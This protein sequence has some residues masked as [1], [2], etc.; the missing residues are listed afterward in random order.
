MSAP[1]RSMFSIR[2][3]V[4]SHGSVM[5]YDLGREAIAGALMSCKPALQK[6]KPILRE[7]ENNRIDVLS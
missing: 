1:R 4:A 5:R 6:R 2:D 7:P 3:F